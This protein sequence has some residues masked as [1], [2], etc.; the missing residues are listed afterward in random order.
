[1]EKLPKPCQ[2]QMGGVAL[3]CLLKGASLRSSSDK[4]GRTCTV[5]PVMT[6]AEAELSGAGRSRHG[7]VAGWLHRAAAART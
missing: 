6:E 3:Y 1:M 7:S 5:G 4:N 2:R